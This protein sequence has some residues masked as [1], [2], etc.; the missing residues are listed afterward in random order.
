VI[1]HLPKQLGYQFLERCE[2]ITRKLIIV[3]TPN[4]FV[5]QGPEH[6]NEHMRHLS[7]WFIHDFVGL[8]YDVFGT[9]GTRYLRGYGAGLKYPYRGVGTLDVLMSRILRA[10]TSPR[11]AFNLFAVKDVRGVPAR[12]AE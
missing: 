10:R 4:G 12:W 9:T 5:P 7:G 11:H 3:E 8:G 2:A 1:E 6:G